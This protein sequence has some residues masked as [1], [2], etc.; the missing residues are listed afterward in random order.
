ML[1]RIMLFCTLLMLSGIS[2]TRAQ[3]VPWG[4]P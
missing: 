3:D 2:A 1:I 4:S